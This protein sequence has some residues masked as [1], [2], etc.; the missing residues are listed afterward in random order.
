MIIKITCNNMKARVIATMTLKKKGVQ[1]KENE[2]N[3][4]KYHLIRPH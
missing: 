2:K 3:K 4:C 1:Y